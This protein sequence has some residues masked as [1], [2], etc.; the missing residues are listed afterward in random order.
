MEYMSAKEAAEKWGISHRRVTVLCAENRIAGAER[1]GNMWLIPRAAEKP[2]DGRREGREK[3]DGRRVRPFLKWAGG[4][5]QLLGEIGKYY[6]FAHGPTV[7]YAEPFVGGGAV[8]FD[9]LDK[10]A[11]EAVYISDSNPSLINAY[12][13]IRDGAG[14]LIE[15]LEEMQ[16]AFL[17]LD[18][19]G[20]K[21]YYT[22]AR[23]RYNAL[24]TGG[25]E[26]ARLDKAALLVFLNRTCFNGLYRVN[27]KGFFN[28]PMGAYK[29]PLICDRENL[30]AVSQKLR[31]VKIVCGDY[32]EA[33]SFIDGDTFVYF[34]PPYRPITR[35]A[36]FTAYTENQFL[37]EEQA[38]LARFAG[39]MGERG[40]KVLISNSDPRNADPADDFFDTLYAAWRI[41]RVE[42]AR[43]INSDSRARGRIKEL[44]ISNF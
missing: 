14:P 16:Q 42:A 8:L 35:T 18:T 9:I 41:E 10:Y 7:K 32:R 13:V 23:N 15:I 12:R 39:E 38:Q 22:A 3:K 44:L 24:E 1:V 19:A 26:R 11:P 37:D 43:M 33:A 17:P 27:R 36:S 30:L 2:E 40:A 4:K 25:D 20:R 21:A 29:N 28:V 5:G 6:P 31:G 34:D